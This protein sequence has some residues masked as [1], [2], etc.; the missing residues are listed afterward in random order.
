MG[1]FFCSRGYP[2]EHT[3]GKASVYENMSN[4]SLSPG[5][6]PKHRSMIS[7]SYT[8]GTDADETTE[9]VGHDQDKSDFDYQIRSTRNMKVG[10]I[11]IGFLCLIAQ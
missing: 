2:P 9:S 6:S 5:V 10:Y 1:D 8:E 4:A 11:T 3:P 7:I